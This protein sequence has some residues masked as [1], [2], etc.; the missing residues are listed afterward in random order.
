[1]EQIKLSEAIRKGA[2]MH[3]KCRGKLYTSR[4]D[5][6]EKRC[7]VTGTC[8]MGAAYFGAGLH[9]G[10]GAFIESALGYSTSYV[11]AQHPIT[12]DTLPLDNI[13]TRLNDF[14]GWS[15]PRIARW[16]ESIGY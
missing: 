15:R 10:H 5:K 2:K 8:A 4:W 9:P 6:Q 11:M 1:V 14:F 3:P 13:I 16:L 12:N 7:V